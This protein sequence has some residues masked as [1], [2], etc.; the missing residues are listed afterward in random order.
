MGELLYNIGLRGYNFGI[1]IASLFND[2]AQL[3]VKG[4]RN[5]RKYLKEQVDRIDPKKTKVWFH[6]SSL[7]EFEQGRPVMEELKKSKD[8]SLIISFYSPSGFEIMKSWKEADVVTYLP[9]DTKKNAKDFI[10]IIEPAAVIFVKYDLW[11]H[12]LNELKKKKIPSVLISARF[13]PSQIFFKKWAPWYRELLF[14]LDQILVQ[15]QDSLDLLN[16]ISYPRAILTGDTRYDRVSELSI[17]TDRFSDIESF[18]VDKKVFIAGSSWPLDEKVMSP[19]ILE[20]PD[21][22]RF[23]VAPHDISKEHVQSLLK[24]FGGKAILY[25]ELSNLKQESILILDTIG[26]LSRLY[27]YADIS[28]IGGAFKEGLHNILEP[29]AY[30]I[31][32]ITGPDHSGFP[33]GKALEDAGGL[34]KIDNA[35]GFTEIM[36][37]L[38]HDEPF[39]KQTCKQSKS[40]IL[41]NSGASE[42]TVSTIE[43]TIF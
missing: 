36:H 34:F 21:D 32:V 14:L 7:G 38:I 9:L 29:A 33:E 10:G 42:R 24:S 25:S 30:A 27:K 20:N 40:F 35:G 22:L 28:Y 31:P 19:Y 8:I 2:K 41:K 23:I 15:D 26:M 12:Y 4:R 3:W 16:S 5:W 6:V 1:K 43:T 11:F 18:I 37:K 17:N 39:Y 13:Y